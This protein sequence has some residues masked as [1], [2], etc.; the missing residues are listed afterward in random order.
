M[1]VMPESIRAE[2][3]LVYKV[4]PLFF[5]RDFGDPLHGNPEERLDRVADNVTTKC[6]LTASRK[7][8]E[9]HVVWSDPI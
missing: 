6:F 8:L 3:L 5:M 7:N 2:T 4:D 1:H 9:G